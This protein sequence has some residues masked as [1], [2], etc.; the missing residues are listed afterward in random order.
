M[1]DRMTIIP[2]RMLHTTK[3]FKKYVKLS[4]SN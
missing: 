1:I 3:V 2:G 4:F